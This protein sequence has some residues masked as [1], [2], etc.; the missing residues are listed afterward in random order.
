MIEE[1]DVVAVEEKKEDIEV[2]LREELQK[3]YDTRLE[4]EINRI[5][6]QLKEQNQKVVAEALERYRVEMAPPS[7]DDV[8]KLLDQEYVE[9][10]VKVRVPKEEG[11][12]TRE[13]EFTISELPQNVERK[14][15]KKI[16]SVLIPFSS[17]LAGISMNL[18]EGDAAK[19]IVQIMNTFEPLLDTMS[20]IAAIVL[21]PDDELDWLDEG[22]VRENLS[23][24]RIVRIVTAQLEANHIR[25]FFSLV[26]QGSKLLR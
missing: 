20:G 8:Q 11:E 23:S 4:A 2:R 6:A 3:E 1:K 19:K 13:H 9:F 18:L 25:D 22:W 26:F 5:S 16:K 14:I 10:K 24:T 15:L 17:D 7:Q 21:N 12:G